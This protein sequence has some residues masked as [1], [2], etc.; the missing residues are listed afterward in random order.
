VKK[1]LIRTGLET[2]YFSGAHRVMQRFFGGAGAIL[3][4]HHV[5]PPRRGAFQPNRMLEVTPVFFERL[6]TY[7]RKVGIDIVSL[8]ELHRRLT[9]GDFSRRVVCI[10]FDDG[11]RDTRTWAYPILKKHGVPF[12]IYVPTSF[13]DRV[14]ELWWL[15]LEAAIAKTNRIALLV[16][17]KGRRFDCATIADKRHL[18]CE[19]YK[20]LRSLPSDEDI[21]YVV[22]DLAARY[23]VDMAAINDDLCM[24]WAEI[25]ELAADPLVTIGAHTVNH[26]ILA[27]ASDEVVRSELKMGRAVV[28]AAIGI[29]PQ[30]LAYPFGDRTAV[31]TREFQIAAELGFKTAV[32]TEPAML[33]P[34]HRNQMMA[35]PRIAINGEFQRRRYMGVLMSGAATAMWDGIGRV[36]AA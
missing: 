20:W 31:G 5:R 2:L 9:D 4:L 24:T 25:G 1:S 23:D 11:Y 6:V 17:G 13:P 12:A 10:T 14:G 19:M 22:R 7:L 27:K 33:F 35:L 36:E 15:V 32:T 8:D 26:P 21:R 16:D 28:E 18:F 30:H 3:T 29:R 34:E